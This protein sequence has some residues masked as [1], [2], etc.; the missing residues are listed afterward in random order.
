MREVK[1]PT[2]IYNYLTVGEPNNIA[3]RNYDS[4]LTTKIISKMVANNDIN[5]NEF[6]I[7]TEDS[8][9]YIMGHVYRE[10]ANVAIDIASHTAGVEKVVT[11]LRYI[12]LT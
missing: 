7:V 11:L 1:G 6:K 8:T 2:V 10:Q 4:W 9:V 3:A 12:K 5:P